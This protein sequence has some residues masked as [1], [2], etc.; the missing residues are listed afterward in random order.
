MNSQTASIIKKIGWTEIDLS[1]ESLKNLNELILYSDS[2]SQNKKD[3]SFNK[4]SFQNEVIESAIKSILR[5]SNQSRI[6]VKSLIKDLVKHHPDIK[7]FYLTPPYIITHPP[8]E[9]KEEGDYHSDTIKYCGKSYTSWTP[10]NNYKIDY[11]PLSILSKSHLP[12]L[13]II[14]KILNKIKFSNNINQILKFLLIKPH[15]LI[16]KK[17]CTYLW[18]SDLIHKGNLNETNKPHAA[19]VTR[20]SE[21]PLYY[22]PTVKI[23]EIVNN[24]NLTNNE[25]QV[26][27][28][29]LTAM[30]F[31]I[32][33]IAQK[34]KDLIKYSCDLRDAT[35]KH[36][37]KHVSFALSV[38]AQKF[39]NNFSSNLDLISFILAKENLV[40]LER[41][42]I[43]FKDQDIS[44]DVIK[45]LFIDKDLSY[46]ETL[47]IKKF[48]NQ[49]LDDVIHQKK[50]N[51]LE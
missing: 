10:I 16:I 37:L 14:Y 30:I 29:D 22:E 32:C 43:K 39:Q 5:Y 21:K 15:D 4:D 49:N 40:S 8:K 2:I 45:K 20:I 46:Q 34:K 7:N 28:N 48:K 36:L 1:S 26:T 12:Y 42:L 25:K 31:E 38:I 35:D 44:R 13:K 18:H 41:F 19:L 23:S 47:I 24:S 11:P 51:W 3:V 27:F 17:T 9:L 50:I 6:F 33:E